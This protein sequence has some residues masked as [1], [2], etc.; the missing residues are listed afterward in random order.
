[1]NTQRPAV[2][3]IAA[4]LLI[5]LSLF[6]GGLGIARQFGLLGV[7]FGGRQFFAGQSRN[8]NFTP[9]NGFPSGGFQNNGGIPDQNNQGTTPNFTPN[10]TFNT[11]FARLFSLFRPVTIALD[12][13]LLVLAGVA[14][15][16]LFK[17]QRWGATLAIVLAVLLFLLAIPGLIRIFS[18]TVLIETLTRMLMAVA[19]IV[20]LLLPVARQ[21]YLPVRDAVD[22]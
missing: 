22:D 15:F 9:P 20:L 7:G 18:A 1:M 6:V 8:R 19:V 5:V 2:V 13:I 14:A 10:Q 3:T 12:I 21:S 16:G 17:N 11:G 4:I